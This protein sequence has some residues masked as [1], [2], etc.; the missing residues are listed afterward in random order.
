MSVP[1]VQ[2]HETVVVIVVVC[3]TVADVCP[4]GRCHVTGVDGW[5]ELIDVDRS[6]K[7][8]EFWNV[9]EQVLEIERFEGSSLRVAVHADRTACIDEKYLA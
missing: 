6:I 1:S 2:Y 9:D 3:D 8:L 4:S 7:L 5:G